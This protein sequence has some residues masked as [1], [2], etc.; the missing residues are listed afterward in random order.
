MDLVAEVDELLRVN[1]D[2]VE[3][4][5]QSVRAFGGPFINPLGEF[6][7]RRLPS[8]FLFYCYK[9]CIKKQCK[10][11]MYL[12]VCVHDVQ[13]SEHANLVWAV[14]NHVELVKLE[15]FALSEKGHLAGLEEI[16]N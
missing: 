6:E 8:V 15:T 12:P 4:S 3:I 11:L 14:K 7:V 1:E 13:V 10:F 9:K 2:V 16:F 5:V